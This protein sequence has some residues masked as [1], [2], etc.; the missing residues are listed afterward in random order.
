MSLYFKINRFLE[1]IAFPNKTRILIGIIAGGMVSIGFLMFISIYALKYDYETL[2]QSRTMPLVDLEEIKDLYSVNIHDTLYDLE[3]DNITLFNAAEVI[4][5]ANQI[6]K[7]QWDDYEKSISYEVSGIA[8][9]AHWWLSLFLLSEE[10]P[11]KSL[12]QVGVT[13]KIKAKM[14]TIDSRVATVLSLVE[15]GK[16]DEVDRL[17]NETFL[18]INTLNI[19]IS[20]LI[21]IHL[22]DAISEKIKTERI[23]QTSIIMLVLLISLVFFLSILVSIVLT[24][25][26][27]TLHSSLETKVNIKTKALRRLND[28]LEKRVAKE[29]ELNRKKDQIMFQQSRL[30]SLGEMLQNVAHQWRQ[31][32]SALTMIIQSF[33]T[34]HFTGKLTPA[35]IEERVKDA[36]VLASGMSETL[37]DFR[38]F[39]NPNKSKKVFDL[40]LSIQKAIDLTSYLLEKENIK[41]SLLMQENIRVFGF[42]NELSHVVLNLINNAKDAL[43][44][45]KV[46]K[47][48]HIYVKAA[49]KEIHISII[50]NAGGINEA[51]LPK[52]FDPYFT[53]KH[54]SVGTGIGLYMSKQIIEEHMQGTISCKNIH[55]KM[56][57]GQFYKCAMFTIIVPYQQ[58]KESL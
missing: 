44:K 9:F 24:N 39:F 32:L 45:K 1:Q 8:G 53:T 12:Y 37:D 36:S 27:K 47:K 17:V 5:L 34:K 13:S 6:I 4:S 26:F 11:T 57:T 7:E 18:E 3:K 38:T 49:P 15:R 20:S 10:A 54:Q 55:H 56:G 48:I 41:L 28:S 40:R 23:F 30:A 46:D 25:H 19:Y 31:P 58:P 22:K 21:G 50:D 14:N 33:E 52:I 16:R 29:V 51:V 35:F 43:S 42:R 2:F